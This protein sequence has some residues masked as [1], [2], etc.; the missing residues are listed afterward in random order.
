MVKWRNG[1]MV[2]WRNGEMVKWR[3]VHS[4]KCS[5]NFFHPASRILYPVSCIPHPA[6]CIPH[7][8]SCIPHPASRILHPVGCAHLRR[9]LQNAP[10]APPAI[11]YLLS[12]IHFATSLLRYFAIRYLI[13]LCN[14][15]RYL[16]SKELRSRTFP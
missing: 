1:E 14:P 5:R 15:R 4:S 13:F 12:V 2:K 16:S 11:C 7:P 6:S 8:V 9:L 3:N 10:Y